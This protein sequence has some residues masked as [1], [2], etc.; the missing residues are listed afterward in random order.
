M[1]E[2]GELPEDPERLLPSDSLLSLAEYLEMARAVSTQ[3]GFTVAYYLLHSD[4]PLLPAELREATGLTPDEFQ[5]ALDSLTESG[6]VKQEQLPGEDVPR[7]RATTLSDTLLTEGFLELLRQEYDF[8]E[9][10]SG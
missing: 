10:Y 7:Y 6:L 4:D 1:N 3:P 8:S 9:A 2:R 5:A